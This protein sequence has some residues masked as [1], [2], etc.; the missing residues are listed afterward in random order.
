MAESDSDSSEASFSLGD[1]ESEVMNPERDGG[2]RARAR[3]GPFSP[4][5]V[6]EL[7][8]RARELD[9][10][11]LTDELASYSVP[12]AGGGLGIN[13][14]DQHGFCF[15]HK[16]IEDREW[17][18][19]VR[20]LG[21]ASLVE[22]DLNLQDKCGRSPLHLVIAAGSE[23]EDA[24]KTLVNDFNVDL[25]KE[26]H[27]PLRKTP[28]Y[29]AVEN[30]NRQAY[31]VLMNNVSKINF[32]IP[33]NAAARDLAKA[34][35]VLAKSI[36]VEPGMADEQEEVST[37]MA[38]YVKAP[39]TQSRAVIP[40]TM[41]VNRA[42]R[43]S[44][45]LEELEELEIMPTEEQTN[46]QRSRIRRCTETDLQGLV[47]QGD[48]QRCSHLLEGLYPEW[49]HHVICNGDS[50]GQTSL[51]VAAWKGQ[52]DICA[53][54]LDHLQ[55]AQL[56]VNQRSKF[57]QAADCVGHTALHLAAFQGH[58]EVCTYLVGQ[59]PADSR[60]PFLRYC[61]HSR[62]TPLHLA[63]SKN[64]RETCKAIIELTSQERIFPLVAAQTDQQQT[65][66]HLAANGRY[67]SVCTTI[68]N[69]LP[70]ARQSELL[71]M[72]DEKGETALHIIAR[73]S[74]F[75]LWK[76]VIGYLSQGAQ[77]QLSELNGTSL[78]HAAAYGGNC[79]IFQSVMAL[80][81]L[82][83]GDVQENVDRNKQTALH[84]AAA[85]AHSELCTWL[86]Q[87]ISEEERV[88]FLR[89]PDVF[90]QTALQA[91]AQNQ[92]VEI[93]LFENVLQYVPAEQRNKL[94]ARRNTT[95]QSTIYLAAGVSGDLELFQFLQTY[96]TKDEVND[97]ML[98][99][100]KSGKTCLH[101]AARRGFSEIVQWILNNLPSE[102]RATLI[103][104]QDARGKTALHEAAQEGHKDVCSILL[105]QVTSA[106][107]HALVTK[108]DGYK[109]SAV[110]LAV[111]GG[112][113]SVVEHLLCHVREDAREE[114]LLLGSSLHDAARS[115]LS[116]L[117]E[118]LLVAL[119]LKKRLNVLTSLDR[120]GQ[121]VLHFAMTR[122]NTNLCR[123]LL[124][125]LDEDDRM[126]ALE[127]KNKRDKTILDIPAGRQDF[128]GF[129]T[130][131]LDL[132]ASEVAGILRRSEQ[133]SRRHELV[134]RLR[135]FAR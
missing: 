64:Q 130:L 110:A 102:K 114:L 128:M 129:A 39:E 112:Y 43:H 27:S 96:C 95:G 92:E 52:V 1:S 135:H 41:T 12:H 48:V 77:H 23:G 85:Q 40:D 123:Q 46:T 25:N 67:G 81:R 109:N 7:T 4:D 74:K 79:D 89:K 34:L 127:M 125:C 124:S 106:D 19:F 133:D 10:E 58:T 113:S 68:L 33:S 101:L 65:A 69:S 134:D 31:E 53:I 121:S 72:V 42:G 16:L 28:L 24:L 105:N 32:E 66:L 18:S 84:I 14:Y 20:A 56:S 97:T 21:P 36:S 17:A 70:V 13:A 57:I 107:R 117:C 22:F 29:Y 50:S 30:T 90:G 122:K 37:E 26:D 80:L 78:L 103:K 47:L 2:P 9:E 83:S 86:V 108:I 15:L 94:I 88:S 118:I 45:P 126:A 120:S 87:Q 111:K 55:D 82:N 131:L 54:L 61:S 62:Q 93:E 100:S 119:P 73:S 35:F 59:V 8:N 44:Y 91:A 98:M 38:E 75:N 51:H 63:A 104:H 76:K 49:K 3:K 60:E 11:S 116:T 115:G 6:D 5:I 99:P 71:L 132:R